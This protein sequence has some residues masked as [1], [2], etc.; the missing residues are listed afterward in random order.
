MYRQ[1]MKFAGTFNIMCAWAS[2]EKVTYGS[3]STFVNPSVV[4]CVAQYTLQGEGQDNPATSRAKLSLRSS[5]ANQ[6]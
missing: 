1:N 3:P 2:L 6:A 4:L 5:S